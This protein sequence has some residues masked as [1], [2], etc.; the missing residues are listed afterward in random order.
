MASNRRR[1]DGGAESKASRVSTSTTPRRAP[2]AAK[3]T[4]MSARSAATQLFSARKSA[5]APYSATRHGNRQ[6]VDPRPIGDKGYLRASVQRL[7]DYLRGAGL[8]TACSSTRALTRPTAR[9]FEDVCSFLFAALDPHW[10]KSPDR[11]FEDDVV[12]VFKT[13]KYPF[14]ISKTGLC[15][16]GTAHTWPALLAALLWLVD[17]VQHAKGNEA[18]KGDDG[19]A[20]RDDSETDERDGVASRLE[21]AGAEGVF[22]E[23]VGDAYA[24]FLR[25]DDEGCDELRR[26]L[27]LAF[28]VRGEALD[29]EF[30]GAEAR[31]KDVQQRRSDAADSAQRLPATLEKRTLMRADHAAAAAEAL[32]FEKLL[33]AADA[34]AAQSVSEAA[35]AQSD[36]DFALAKRKDVEDLRQ[37]IVTERDEMLKLQVQ[38]DQLCRDL[39]A[40]Q[41]RRLEKADQLRQT[42]AAVC[43][44][45]DPAA[46]H[47]LSYARRAAA[48]L[49]VP[50]TAK[51]ASGR[52]L[53][54]GAVDEG[55][56]VTRK[57]RQCA[58]AADRATAVKPALAE[59]ADALRSRGVDVRAEAA[60][61]RLEQD[62]AA[63]DAAAVKRP[64]LN[65]KGKPRQGSH[66]C[67]RQSRR[68]TRRGETTMVAVVG[69]TWTECS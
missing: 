36:C 38:K 32:G 23:F 1:T 22:Y 16:V 30:R 67:G 45:L 49:L 62:R 21:R 10:T 11:K 34:E 29:L 28:E 60:Q 64:R 35:M 50:R 9:D 56:D 5:A 17:L 46:E 65:L 55:D 18:G 63:Q 2:H 69:Q 48:L 54:L 68:D 4:P 51:N 42:R 47:T 13:V 37:R 26:R 66:C 14:Q 8:N 40:L 15:A 44:A 33:N 59:I 57:H 19:E 6:P 61:L 24:L 25:G 43:A 3:A 20:P 7:S 39:E 53:S 58:A 41:A 27:D 52:D 12:D 31:V